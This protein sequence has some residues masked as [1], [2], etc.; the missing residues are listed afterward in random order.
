MRSA[1]WR[2]IK[3]RTSSQREKT[4]RHYCVI[5]YS[6]VIRNVHNVVTFNAGYRPLSMYLHYTV[7]WNGN[8]WRGDER[9]NK[10]SVA[11]CA[12]NRILLCHVSEGRQDPVGATTAYRFSGFRDTILEIGSDAADHQQRCCVQ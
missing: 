9:K 4:P 12:R 5:F 3:S 2:L 6:I 1:T 10:R 11:L 8:G 7:L